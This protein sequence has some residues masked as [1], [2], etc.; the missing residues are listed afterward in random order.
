MVQRFLGDAQGQ[1]FPFRDIDCREAFN[2]VR[3]SIPV[4]RGFI[5]DRHHHPVPHEIDIAADR[6]G[7]HFQFGCQLAAIGEPASLQCFVD[8]QHSLNG[9]TLKTVNARR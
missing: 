3:V 2:F 4:F 6:L 8:E 9:R 7:T 5:L 1:Q